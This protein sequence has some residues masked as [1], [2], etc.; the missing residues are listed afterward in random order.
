MLKHPYLQSY[1]NQCRLQTSFQ[2]RGPHTSLQT[3]N[4]DDEDSVANGDESIY[5]SQI[6]GFSGRSSSSRLPTLDSDSLA[7]LNEIEPCDWP[8]F[9]GNKK[10]TLG[11]SNQSYMLVNNPKGEHSS[12]HWGNKIETSHKCLN[13]NGDIK[14]HHDTEHQ[15][16][17]SIRNGECH[18]S[19]ELSKVSRV[20]IRGQ[21]RGS[22]A[23][24]SPQIP[25]QGG[26]MGTSKR[27]LNSAKRI[28]H[29]MRSVITFLL[30]TFSL[31]E[32]S[33]SL[34]HYRVKHPKL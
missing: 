14:N 12:T 10:D 34:M 9:H 15:G 8:L 21:G 19:K 32:L 18:L 29:E 33:F 2:Q 17:D 31:S 25:S 6:S 7:D 22:F 11:I 5:T 24:D 27:I 26:V 4:D 13:E 23:A 16:S 1:V 30:R 28:Q 20:S 3:C